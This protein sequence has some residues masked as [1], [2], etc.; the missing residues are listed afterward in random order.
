MSYI[1]GIILAIG[2][3]TAI[4]IGQV[5]QKKAVNGI[6]IEQREKDFM[7]TLIHNKTWLSGLLVQEIGRA[8]V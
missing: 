4:N 2:A 6:P 8:H 1:L 7:K 3:G 5:L